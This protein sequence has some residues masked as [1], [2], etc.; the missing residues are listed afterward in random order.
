MSILHLLRSTVVI[1]IFCCSWAVPVA[2]MPAVHGSA[3]ISSSMA[4]TH[5]RYEIGSPRL[6]TLYV[7]YD[8][9][10]DAARGTSPDRAFRTL[11]AAWRSIP[12]H[13]TLTTG[14]QI[15]LAPGDYPE[16]ALPTYWESRY[17]TYQA[18][19][20]VRPA[21]AAHSVRLHGYL[22]IYD[23]RYLY[24]IGVNIVT[25][26]GYGGGGNVVHLEKADHILLR[27]CVLDGFDGKVSQPQETLKANQSRYLF[28]ENSDISG[29]FWFALDTMAVEYGHITGSRI[30]RAGDDCLL[31]KGGSASFVVAD[32]EIYDCG[33]VGISAGE[34]SGMEFLVAPWIRFDAYNMLFVNNIVHDT[35]NAGLAARGAFNA[36]FVGNAFYRI[37]TDYNNGGPLM[38][39]AFGAR[40]CDGHLADCR[41][42]YALGAW[43]SQNAGDEQEIIPNRNVYVYD[44][45]VINPP[46]IRTHYSHITVFGARKPPSGLHLPSPILADDNLQIK[47]NVI[48]NGPADL[49]IGPEESDQGCQPA[50]RTCNVG[51]LRA[52]NRWNVAQPKLVDPSHGDM[53]V[54]IGTLPATPVS[55]V[56]PEFPANDPLGA[57]LPADSFLSSNTIRVDRDGQPRVPG[58]APGAYATER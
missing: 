20:L 39:F 12:M 55:V 14:Y 19:I 6:R 41:R 35:R 42:N 2:A 10:D 51:Q 54:R 44:N 25:D 18:P 7:D 33:V 53:H 8:H 50:N 32:D 45:L 57:G 22:N 52:D 23:T 28:V 38:L 26:R 37:G 48:W 16:S 43:G 24:L 34:G 17:G 56:V 21:A 5:P 13:A 3:S 46:P 49:E 31:L 27:D 11:G 29:A 15:L 40:G 36:A 30:H 9:G 58:G 4:W 1:A 47:G